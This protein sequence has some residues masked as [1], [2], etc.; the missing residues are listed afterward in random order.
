MAFL[1][2]NL[3]KLLV[4]S[5]VLISP[6]DG[7]CEPLVRRTR[8]RAAQPLARRHGGARSAHSRRS[9]RCWAGVAGGPALRAATLSCIFACP[10]RRPNGRPTRRANGH[11]HCTCTPG[12]EPLLG[13]EKRTEPVQ[14]KGARIGGCYLRCATTI[15]QDSELHPCP[16]VGTVP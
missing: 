9:G 4:S 10:P 3:P 13:R 8:L 1:G 15:Q 16:Y 11:G 14:I 2:P 6:R 12:S 5:S 7:P